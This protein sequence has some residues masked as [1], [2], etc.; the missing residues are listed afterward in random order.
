MQ[1]NFTIRSQHNSQKDEIAVLVTQLDVAN[2]KV[3]GFEFANETIGRFISDLEQFA[4]LPSDLAQ[5]NSIRLEGLARR[6][7][8]Q[9]VFALTI[10][11]RSRL[12]AV[13]DQ[14]PCDAQSDAY[15]EMGPLAQL[16]F[17]TA[18]LAGVSAGHYQAAPSP[19]GIAEWG[20]QG[21][22]RSTCHLAEHE[23]AVALCQ[24]KFADSY[25]AAKC[26]CYGSRPRSAAAHYRSDC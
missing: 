15:R 5:S 14:L 13:A 20:C 16:E 23:R 6:F 26:C 21:C 17:K 22:C 2:R 12:T 25:P 4:G 7:H 3:S 18:R 1:K 11:H 9:H 19:H 24:Q 10:V 8:P